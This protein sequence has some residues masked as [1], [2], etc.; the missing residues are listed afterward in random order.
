MLSLLL[1]PSVFDFILII[2][3]ESWVPALEGA[4]RL[5]DAR[6]PARVL[7]SR[8]SPRLLQA[9][10]ALEPQVDLVPTGPARV[11][12]SRS[13]PRLLAVLPVRPPSRRRSLPHLQRALL[14]RLQ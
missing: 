10:P 1:R 13:S 12:R 2:I 11:L 6:L 8:N 14:G 5:R 7:R 3:I 4:A 9:V